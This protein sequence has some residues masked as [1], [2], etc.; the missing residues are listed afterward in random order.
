MKSS[1]VAAMCMCLTLAAG[2]AWAQ[3]N[4]KKDA[5]PKDGMNKSMTAQECKDYMAMK[6]DGNMKKDDAMMKKDAMCT[7]MMNKDGM[8]KDGTMKSGDPMKK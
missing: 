5:M 3:D 7:D 6:K 8:M 4:M 2:A 1:T